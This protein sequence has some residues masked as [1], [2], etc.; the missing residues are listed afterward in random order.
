MKIHYCLFLMA[1]MLL[2]A[3]EKPTYEELL[4]KVEVR[5][6]FEM[7]PPV[8][9]S[10]SVEL[11]E[12]G[13]GASSNNLRFVAQLDR[14]KIGDDFLAL[15]L[16]DE[17][18]VL[19]DDGKGADDKKGDGLFSV[20]IKDD[21]DFIDREL[22]ERARLGLSEDERITRFTNR[23]ARQ[24]S[25]GAVEEFS[26]SK[27]VT[28]QLIEIPIDLIKGL[29]GISDQSKTLMITDLGVVEDPTRTFN[30]CTGVGN[31][32][33]AWT[34]GELMRQL[35]SPNP[36]SIA[37]DLDASNFVRNWLN[38]WAANQVVNGETV[39]ARANV[40]NLIADWETK[41][42]TGSGGILKMQFAPFKLIAIVNRLDLRGN[43]GYGFSNAGEGR[44]VFNAL[45]PT[46]GSQ[47]FT[48]IFEYGIN[49]KSC[50]SVKAFAQEWDDLNSET[51]GSPAYN[52]ALEA[53]TDQ[54]ALSGTNTSKPNQSSL[55]QIRTN[56]R[57]IGV[58]WELREFNLLAS[59][60]LGIVD[61]KQEPAVKF[62]GFNPIAV[63]PVVDVTEMA[64]W[65]NANTPAILAN[66]YEVPLVNPTTTNDFRGGHSLFVGD[67]VNTIWNGRG[68]SGSPQFIV[69]DE[70]R[71][72]FS[73]N[74]CSGCHGG[75]TETIFTH[76]EPSGFGVEAGLSGFLKGIT[77]VDPANRPSGSPTPRTF[78]DLARREADLADLLSSTCLVST[79]FFELAHRLTFVP[80]RMPH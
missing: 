32:S 59:G 1:A 28:G 50:S 22:R 21:L 56:E 52:N 77:V 67:N 72:I 68:T 26:K 24:I 64:A 57:A 36:G 8:A 5:P 19:R 39:T 73:L 79:P 44:F 42:G 62:N 74:T 40:N 46:C 58:P 17:K 49:K 29:K 75:E 9:E 55:N 7:A 60:Q 4:E 43:S 14:E 11:L 34:F 51:L 63:S 31:P 16:N 12:D 47:E 20:L 76:I 65:V 45:T 35:A 27:L 41:S 48:V 53:I 71:H 10:I 25:R 18:V 30:P 69:D 66:N 70:A 13:D 2:A 38:S 23:S 3:C 80:V 54:F 6:E 61:V 33:G 15:M 78:N 37:S